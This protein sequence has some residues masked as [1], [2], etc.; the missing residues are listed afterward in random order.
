MTTGTP[1]AE[2]LIGGHLVAIF[3]AILYVSSVLFLVYEA[4]YLAS[5]SLYGISLAQLYIYWLRSKTDG[6][7]LRSVVWATM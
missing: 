6:I 4:L 1:T 3:V 2:G 5:G 7:Y